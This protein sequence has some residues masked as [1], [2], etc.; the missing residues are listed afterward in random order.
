VKYFVIYRGGLPVKSG[1]VVRFALL[2]VDL[3]RY[4]SAGVRHNAV[5]TI[6]LSAEKVTVNGK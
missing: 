6:T 4:I 1:D 5:V 2:P 3:A